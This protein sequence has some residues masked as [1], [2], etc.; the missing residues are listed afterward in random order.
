MLTDAFFRRYEGTIL[1]PSFG[2]SERR[3]LGQAAQLIAD[4]LFVRNKVRYKSSEDDPAMKAQEVAH[5]KLARELGV[6][7]LIPPR[8]THESRAPNGNLL[9]HNFPRT[10]EQ[11]TKLYLS[12][13]FKDSFSADLFMKY[14]VSFIEIAFQ[15]RANQILARKGAVITTLSASCSDAAAYLSL[16]ADRQGSWQAKE[17]FTIEAEESAFLSHVRELNERFRQAKIPLSYH[18]NLIQ[19]SH[20]NLIEEEIERPFW[21]LISDPKWSVVDQQMKEALDER[22]RRDRNAVSNAF[23]ALESTIRTISNDKGWTCGKERGVANY[24]D[25]LVKERNGKRF[26]EVWEKDA[27]V[28]IFG[29]IRN[30]FG[31]GPPSGQP[32]PSMLPEQQ[33]WAIDTCM[34]WIKSLILR[35]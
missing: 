9:T 24:I 7:Y 3:F 11:K 12:A 20:D 32:L 28:S 22:D 8:F 17:K 1:W 2:V 19:M 4:D 26:I 15:E 10:T 21:S 5:I 13:E 18:N 31:H 35:S 16:V 34:V 14:R 6:P 33:A 27:L 23:N 25:N 29:N 30:E